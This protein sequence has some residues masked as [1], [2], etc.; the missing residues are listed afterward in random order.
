MLEPQQRATFT[1][2]L[3]PPTGFRLVQ[4]IGTTFTLDLISALAVPL[5]FSAS[6]LH[7]A[8]DPVSTFAA[9]SQAADAIDIFA[10]AGEITLGKHS[11][12]VTYLEEPI[13]AVATP[14]GI[15]H[16]KVWMLEF[17]RGG[18]HRFRLIS[19]SRNLTGDR[20]WDIVVRLDGNPSLDGGSQE[21]NE[22]IQRLVRGLPEL[23][24]QPL[25][26]AR[27]QRILDFAER[28]GSVE[29]ET[30]DDIR[31]LAF[32]TLGIGEATPPKVSGNR[33]LVISPF[34]TD[35]R[36][37]EL[38][39]SI[40]GETHLL[41]RGTSLDRLAPECFDEQL[42]VYDFDQA[43]N[44]EAEDDHQL[45]GLHAKAIIVDQSRRSRIWLGS[46]NATRAAWHDNVEFMVEFAASTPSYGVATTMAA[47]GELK[48]LYDTA[49]GEAE[50][51]DEAARYAVDTALRRLATLAVISRVV[52]G[53]PH[54]QLVWVGEGLE[55]ALRPARANG[56]EIE[57]RL[58]TDL[59]STTTRLGEHEADAT[60]FEG[61]DLTEITAFL[62]ASATHPLLPG[63]QQSTIIP[64]RLL[65]DIADRK[66]ATIARHLADPAA[67]IRLLT[68]LLQLS[69]LAAATDAAGSGAWREFGGGTASSTGL[70]E[71]LVRA[72]ARGAQGLDDA[73]RII[74][75]LRREPESTALPVG[76]EPLW[77]AVWDAHQQLRG[78]ASD[79]E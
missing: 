37:R 41:S 66:E 4:A 28:L 17:A 14:G 57:W 38:R 51:A 74:N 40:R 22:P 79:D 59:G 6:R 15:F 53:A 24:I 70:F 34:V 71:A 63:E 42:H 25:D 52:A 75:F 27:K 68:M 43:A 7:D 32:H 36:M 55:D 3:Q 78:R 29:W 61:L 77:N 5:S 35:D 67:F 54:T 56:I 16:P 44:L 58:L 65:D 12:L 48:V 11:D 21:Q 20:S 8:D 50:P 31:E 13:H 47:L 2:Q 1:E 46:A 45:T 33:A 19:S 76:F 39:A 30:S 62:V 18:E 69:G 64:M 9:I 72:L 60:R 73:Q 26:V 10:Q 23:C 49:G